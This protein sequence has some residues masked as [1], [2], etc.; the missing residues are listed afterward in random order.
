[1]NR[2]LILLLVPVL[3]VSCKQ[4]FLERTPVVGATEANFYKTPEL[5]LI[6]I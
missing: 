6:H 4:E 2:K 5:S 3:L 1:M